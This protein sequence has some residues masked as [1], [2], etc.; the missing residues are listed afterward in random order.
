MLAASR[1]QA[2]IRICPFTSITVKSMPRLQPLPLAARGR[3]PVRWTELILLEVLALFHLTS[4][5][6]LI[7]HDIDA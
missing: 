3:L 1:R 4:T 7:T 6:L 5:T 2:L